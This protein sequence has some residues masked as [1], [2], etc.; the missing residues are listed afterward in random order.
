[1]NLWRDRGYAAALVALGGLGAALCFVPL[2]GLL[3]YESA[4]ATGVVAGLAAAVLTARALGGWA[5]GPLDEQMGGRAQRLFVRLLGRHLTLI[6]PPALL[7]ALNAL[8]VPNCDMLIGLG[9]WALIPTGAVLMGQLCGWVASA[10]TARPVARVMLAVGLLV[11]NALA[12][13]LHLALQPPITGHQWLIGYMSG[14]I[15]D[16]ALSIPASLI[17]YRVE[18]AALA[19][20]TIWGLE[21]WR[22]RRAGAATP[23]RF[24]ALAGAAGL[25]FG[26]MFATEQRV[27]VRV[28][29]AMIAEELGGRLETEH[30]VI[31][32]PRQRDFVGQLDE[33]AADHEFRYAEMQAFF[34]T[35]PVARR[36]R[37]VRSFVYPDREAKG[38]LMGGRRT[39]V[40]KIWLRE[41]HILWRGFGD[42]L[43]AHELA[44]VFT[45]PFGA[46]PL[47]LSMQNGVGVNMG[48]V[49]GAAT[50]A[51]WP[52]S[53]LTPHEASAAM[54][55]LELAPDIRGLVGASGFWTQS[56]GRAYTLMGSFVRHLIDTRGIARFRRVYADGDFQAAYDRPAGELVGEWE[57]FLDEIELTDEQL[58]VARY[59]YERPS[60]FGK[61][62]ART[63]A[64][65][66]R[67]AEL[68][69]EAGQIDQARALYDQIVAFDPD[70]VRYQRARAR[71]LMRAGQLEDALEA[72]DGL[73]ADE[74]LPPAQRASLEHLRGDV[75]WQR[76]RLDLARRAYV[77]CE[78]IGVPDA[79]RRMLQL[80]QQALSPAR[81][82]VASLART[83]LLE[84]PA[85]PISLYFPM[86]WAHQRPTDALAAYLVGRRLW[87]ARRWT[88]ARAELERAAALGLPT[89]ALRQEN[90]RLLGAAL[91]HVG[92]LDRAASI[93][94]G[95]AE[96]DLSR[97]KTGAR[98]WSARIAWRRA[99]EAE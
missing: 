29:R 1:M 43:L 83:Y 63:V 30:F 4:A 48:L 61:V 24:A 31:Y 50:A 10:I 60:I 88:E 26:G 72:L 25:I 62:C 44:H 81:A 71:L 82:E 39:L 57:A 93:F 59:R 98:E 56:S 90:Q 95:L 16:E 54:R 14:S 19:L 33:L 66:R 49:E 68:A 3:G 23:R 87:G 97:I 12:M 17:W 32:Y 64:E 35:D 70:N 51:D 2:F 45:E 67:R 6:V 42:H 73:L 80:K 89:E 69:A 86:L 7:L 92:Q 76:G 8:R 91:Y 58:Q 85:P 40:A 41:I 52:A 77:S 28:V 11:A 46:G 5:R 79:A 15:Y 55:R 78:V 21:A 20:A 18:N 22:R 38:R 74:Q 53:E 99:Q 36:G 75:H 27:G 37:K 47:R 34:G 84:E 9:F 94:E 96:S 13:G 65:L